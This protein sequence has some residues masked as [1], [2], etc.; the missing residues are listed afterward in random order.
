MRE[1]TVT[2][3]FG[4]INRR[5]WEHLIHF[6]IKKNYVHH[7]LIVLPRDNQNQTECTKRVPV[8]LNILLLKR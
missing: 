2:L 1:S 8:T 3:S 4:K 5:N 6:L 7:L